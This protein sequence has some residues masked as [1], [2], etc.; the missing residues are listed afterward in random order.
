LAD[1]GYVVTPG[2][3]DREMWQLRTLFVTG[4]LALAAGVSVDGAV[5]GNSKKQPPPPP[6]G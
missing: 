3:G 1:K 6:P 5:A 2:E 4:V